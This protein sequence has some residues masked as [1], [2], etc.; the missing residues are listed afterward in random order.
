MKKL[1]IQTA[2]ELQI[3]PVINL[4]LTGESGTGKTTFGARSPRPLILQ[5][6]LQGHAAIVAANPDALVIPISSLDDLKPV[7]K[8]LNISTLAADE[9]GPYLTIAGHKVGSLIIDSLTALQVAAHD[10]LAKEEEA[11]AKSSKKRINKF[12]VWGKLKT[13]IS[14]LLRWQRDL[15]IHTVVLALEK[16]RTLDEDISTQV[17]DLVGSMSGQAPAF[18]NACAN[19]RRS[20]ERHVLVWSD[21]KTGVPTKRPPMTDFSLWPR[22][23]SADINVT[24]LQEFLATNG[25]SGK[26]ADELSAR[27]TQEN[28]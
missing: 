20:G 2:S 18:F 3:A 15:G 1:I 8:Q 22:Y 7:I 17:I 16:T 5:T 27:I 19:I 24:D 23:T 6:E 14:W 26:M 11:A 13:Q 12:S 4:L 21:E 28:K 9:L 25:Q 10:E